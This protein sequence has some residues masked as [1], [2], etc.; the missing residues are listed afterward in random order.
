MSVPKF[1][2]NQE[3]SSAVVKQLKSLKLAVEPWENAF[4]KQEELKEL[5]EILKEEDQ[6]LIADLSRS[7]DALFGEV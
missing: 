6:D 7:I 3:A 4:K 2:D 5:A 1:W